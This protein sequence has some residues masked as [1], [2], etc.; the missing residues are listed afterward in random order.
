MDHI[1][2]DILILRVKVMS[3]AY[4]A[5]KMPLFKTTTSNKSSIKHPSFHNIIAIQNR[6]QPYFSISLGV[7]GLRMYALYGFF[8]GFVYK[9]E[10]EKKK[11]TN[12]G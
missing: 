10:E 5:C 11:E 3:W 7:L 2:G 1:Y 8:A 6:V 9:Y 12:R 4:S